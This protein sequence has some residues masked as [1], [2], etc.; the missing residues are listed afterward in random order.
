MT[1]TPT[2]VRQSRDAFSAV[3]VMEEAAT[4]AEVAAMVATSLLSS[5]S[6]S[7]V[8][9]VPE[10]RARPIRMTTKLPYIWTQRS[11]AELTTFTSGPVQPGEHYTFQLAVYAHSTD[12]VVDGVTFSDLASS[13]PSPAPSSSSSLAAIAS[14]AMHC[15]NFNGSDYWGRSYRAEEDVLLAQ[16]HVVS[17]WVAVMVPPT[18]APGVYTGDATVR[19][20]VRGG[21]E[22]VAI[23]PT[24]IQLTVSGPVSTDGGD[25]QQWRGTR[26]AWLDSTLGIAGDTVP[27][28]FKPLVLSS[29]NTATATAAATAITPN[30]TART[31]PSKTPHPD[32]SGFVASMLD[33]RIAIG[34]LGLPSAVKVGTAASPGNTANAVAVDVLAAPVNLAIS[35]DGAA[36]APLQSTSFTRGAATNMSVTWS[37]TAASAHA[38]EETGPR[39]TTAVSV[40]G[41][42]DCTGYMDYTVTIVP[43]AGAKTVDINLNLPSAPANALMAMGLGM[44]GGYIDEMPP[45]PAPFAP[46]W[47]VLDMGVSVEA[48]NVRVWS[49]AHQTQPGDPSHE[50]LDMSLQ[51]GP[52]PQG[53]WTPAA[54]MRGSPGPSNGPQDFKFGDQM[55]V[56]SRYT[57]ENLP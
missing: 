36:P 48:D 16:G 41:S 34:A 44:S 21:G 24:K 35:V 15:M 27:P 37:A 4:A 56:T 53:P 1:V 9:V 17:L 32:A 57:G 52:S 42:L 51:S 8:I 19:V 3:T 30:R 39:S 7:P 45:P 23:P 20:R 25:G 50:P 12:V 31:R 29:A 2:L 5:A 26:L 33:K 22:V 46:V 18:A 43:P 13:S 55:T 40:E 54:I 49:S 11:H 10:D 6:S 38:A 47:L 14:S 28:P